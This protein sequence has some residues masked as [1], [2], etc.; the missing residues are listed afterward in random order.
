M[1]TGLIR[2]PHEQ[3]T[4]NASNCLSVGLIWNLI[5]S[6][7]IPGLTANIASVF[8]HRCYF[9]LEN[10]ISTSQ[11]SLQFSSAALILAQVLFTVMLFKFVIVLPDEL[12]TTVRT[13]SEKNDFPPERNSNPIHNYFELTTTL[14]ST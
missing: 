8:H 3:R 14:I 13:K 12:L 5:S 4:T 1:V 10:N 11:I 7:I 2:R 6:G 9:T